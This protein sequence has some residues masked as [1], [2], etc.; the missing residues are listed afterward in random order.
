MRP[1][2]RPHAGSRGERAGAA[3]SNPYNAVPSVAIQLG[4]LKCR[5]LDGGRFKLDGGAMFGIIPKPLWSRLASADDQNRIDLAMT[6]LLIETAGRRILV[7]TGCGDKFND[8][9]RAIWSIS[10]HWLLDSLRA[11]GI[12]PESIDTVIL[13][14]LHFDHAG[15]STRHDAD[16]N[17]R[18]TFP[19]AR[20]VVQRGE[21]ED[22]KSGHFVMTATYRAENLE[23]LV[24]AGLL[25]LVDGDAEIAPGVAVRKFPG[26]TRHQQGV[27]LQGGGL[28]AVQPA[29]LMPTSAHL[30][31]PYNMAYD[32][33]PYENMQNKRRLIEEAAAGGWLMLLAQDPKQLAYSI[34]RNERGAYALKPLE[35]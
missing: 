35:P 30:G 16:G 34:S 17:L 31:L 28:T 21:W 9:E 24:E 8:K 7:E 1:R 19:R 4:D 10:D 6:C 22:Y 3:V 14:H 15:G 23:P 5:I 11:G 18:P 2:S 32:L 13:T 29:D 20:Y 27:I 26:H 33:L 25:D 12:E